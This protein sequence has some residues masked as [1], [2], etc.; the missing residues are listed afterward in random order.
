MQK[1]IVPRVETLS[2]NDITELLKT[3]KKNRRVT[4][5]RVNYFAE[6]MARGE[7]QVTGD[8]VKIDWDGK[9]IDAQHR[10]LAAQQAGKPLTT[11]VVR[12]LD[13]RVRAHVDITRPRSLADE[14]KMSGVRGNDALLQGVVKALISLRDT[15]PEWHPAAK[16]AFTGLSLN[17]DDLFDYYAKN[18]KPISAAVGSLSNLVSGRHV[19]SIIKGSPAIAMW[20]EF[21]LIESPAK[22]DEFWLAV[23][24]GEGMK[25]GDP[26]LML[27]NR[28]LNNVIAQANGRSAAN[29]LI[30]SN[31][32]YF[33]ICI[34]AWDYWIVGEP[35]LNLQTGRGVASALN[36]PYI[37]D[38]NATKADLERVKMGR[39]PSNQ[40][41]EETA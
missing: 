36:I 9:L 28:L 40:D 8:T 13:P 21:S 32:D 10:L 17:L 2:L 6:M 22:A 26:R 20:V 25:S 1:P 5:S 7:W 24:T 30:V 18:S 15:Q 35:L 31:Y 11:V 4:K 34:R 29:R 33:R 27:R 3:N 14:I 12:G 38:S 39:G 41:E 37:L 16:R 23:L 19:K